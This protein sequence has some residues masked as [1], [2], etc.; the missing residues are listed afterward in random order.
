MGTEDSFHRLSKNR[1]S[2]LVRLG[3]LLLLELCFD[4]VLYYPTITMET[5]KFEGETVILHVKRFVFTKTI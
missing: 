3:P 1:T 4:Y 2:C 5:K